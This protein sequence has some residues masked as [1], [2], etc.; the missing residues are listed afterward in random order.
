MLSSGATM[1][2]RAPPSMVMLQMVM[3]A[4][5]ESARMASPAY[6]MTWS[7]PPEMPILPM[8]ARTMSLDGDAARALAGKDDVHGL[9]CGCSR[10]CVARTCSTSLV[11]MPKASAPKAPCV[12]V[13]LSPQTMVRPG[14]VMPS[15][16]PMMCTMP[17]LRLN[18]SNR[19]MPWR[20]GNL[21]Q[22]LELQARGFVIEDGQVAVLG[23]HGMVHHRKGQVGAANLAAGGFEAG[24]CLRPK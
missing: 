2:A 14:C 17:W 24:K 4:S 11:P 19:R 5:M 16:G 21:R 12:E 10:H 20:G 23:G 18:I 22:R 9:R 15:S 13:W 7:V 3:R 8:S 1:P 6:S